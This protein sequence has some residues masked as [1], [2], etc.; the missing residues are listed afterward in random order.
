MALVTITVEGG[1]VSYSFKRTCN[2]EELT[3]MTEKILNLFNGTLKDPDDEPR[4]V[5]T[6]EEWEVNELRIIWRNLNSNSRKVL[7]ALAERPEGYPKDALEAALD[8]TGY[9]IGGSLTAVKRQAN[10]FPGKKIIYGRDEDNG[11]TMPQDVAKIVKE[12]SA[13]QGPRVRVKRVNSKLS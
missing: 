3:R 8:M 1:S 4:V 10:N 9:A 12:V 5:P 11:Y 6:E 7:L 13:M 2:V